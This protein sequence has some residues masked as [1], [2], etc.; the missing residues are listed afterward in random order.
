MER[1]IARGAEIREAQKRAEQKWNRFLRASLAAVT[2]AA[3]AFFSIAGYA[4][5]Q[6]ISAQTREREALASESRTLSLLSQNH[7]ASRQFRAALELALEAMPPINQAN[8]RPLIPEAEAALLKALEGYTRNMS[9]LHA[10]YIMDAAF[11]PDGNSLLT[12]DGSRTATLWDL[13]SRRVLHKWEHESTVHSVSLSPAIDRAVTF[14]Q[15]TMRVWDTKGGQ[16]IGSPAKTTPINR[17][18]VLSPSGRYL[19]TTDEN[20]IIFIWNV[21]TATVA[22][23]FALKGQPKILLFFPDESHIAAA[24]DDSALR[25]WSLPEGQ[26]VHSLPMPAAIENGVLVDEG[27]S[28]VLAGTAGDAYIVSL[29]STPE[30]SHVLTGHSK[31][32]LSV[33]R[34]PDS[35]LVATASASGIARLWELHSGK[36]RCQM[37]NEGD[38]AV[39]V[40][41]NK[42]GD[43]VLTSTFNPP[44]ETTQL[45]DAANC[46]EIK[47][48][49][50]TA[51][52]AFLSVFDASGRYFATKTDYASVTLWSS[53]DGTVVDNLNG[54]GFRKITDHSDKI[55][56]VMFSPDAGWLL[57][58][59]NDKTARLYRLKGGSYGSI[60]L[61]EIRES[62]RLSA[63]RVRPETL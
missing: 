42:D 53:E 48:I 56:D 3:L 12:G 16:L 5:Q 15:T 60:P 35:T 40:A 63:L 47:A 25:I 26:L 6:W 36:L 14:T 9:L 43:R 23:K 21:T 4:W 20:D 7:S 11:S 61:R 24:G 29:A 17:G 1:S 41:F 33:A 39:S 19:A 46:K 57:S 58:T 49:P 38:P 18:Q 32:V 50:Q 55:R 51:G 37:S 31:E 13:H 10:Q 28:A 30:I 45:W 34:S 44:R 27:R 59:S 62:V 52:R 2:V 54:I 22:A 8:T